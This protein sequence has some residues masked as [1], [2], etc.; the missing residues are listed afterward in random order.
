M[1]YCRVNFYVPT[2]KKCCLDSSNR[3][4]ISRYFFTYLYDVRQNKG[5]VFFSVH[6]YGTVVL[7]SYSHYEDRWVV[8]YTTSSYHLKHH[9][10]SRLHLPFDCYLFR[11]MSCP[12]QPPRRFHRKL[13]PSWPSS[14]VQE[15]YTQTS[16]T[17]SLITILLPPQSDIFDK[18]DHRTHP[19]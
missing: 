7:C 10:Y 13:L 17:H 1:K 3:L 11:Q 16:Q 12:P 5:K 9:T 2:W 15:I 18:S 4:E 6:D 8:P 14:P 19:M